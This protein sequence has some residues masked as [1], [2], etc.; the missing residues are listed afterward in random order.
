MEYSE[1][2]QKFTASC[3]EEAAE[4]AAELAAD[5]VIWELHDGNSMDSKTKQI[6]SKH[7][8]GLAPSGLLAALWE[9]YVTSE[10]ERREIRE[11]LE[12]S[13]T[14][15]RASVARSQEIWNKIEAAQNEG[16]ANVE[17]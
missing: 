9:Q 4:I 7:R 8:P 13:S 5:A 15:Y 3:D 2:P 10:D 12:H 16:A 11:R 17:S 14:E 6:A 1:P